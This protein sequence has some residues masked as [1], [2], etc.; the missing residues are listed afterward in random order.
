MAP[1][2]SDANLIEGVI[3]GVVP[4]EILTIPLQ[5]K[6]PVH[7]LYENG[8]KVSVEVL[9]GALKGVNRKRVMDLIRTL[10]SSKQKQVWDGYVATLSHDE[11]VAGVKAGEIP[12][13]YDPQRAVD[14]ANRAKARRTLDGFV[15]AI[16]VALRDL[17]ETDRTEV[18]HSQESEG[19]MK[20]WV[21]QYVAGA[22][23]YQV[24]VIFYTNLGYADAWFGPRGE[25]GTPLT[26]STAFST[27]PQA[28]A[29]E[30]AGRMT[31]VRATDARK[32]KKLEKD[33]AR[34]RD[35]AEKDDAR[36]RDEAEKAAITLRDTMLSEVQKAL[37]AS[38]LVESVVQYDDTIRVKGRGVKSP[39]VVELQDGEFVVERSRTGATTNIADVV[40]QV[41]SA[42]QKALRLRPVDLSQYSQFLPHLRR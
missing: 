11:I 33:D 6:L 9:I 16:S 1:T 29:T 15:R 19:K 35:E 23:T 8:S 39:V 5:M 36:K 12:A 41:E 7:V 2:M 20:G 37:K 21:S 14:E 32:R 25:T 3:F 34:K 10:P 24:A 27:S 42:I 40:K 30:V 31:K 4:I 22:P 38:S 26:N 13:E 17:P 28:L 18:H